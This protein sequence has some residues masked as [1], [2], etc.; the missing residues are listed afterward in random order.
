MLFQFYDLPAQHWQHIR[1]TNPIESTFA[2]VRHRT[3]RT[4]G[5]GNRL[6]TL[7]MTF[8]LTREAEKHWRRINGYELIVK[9]FDG[10]RFKNGIE[11]EKA[12]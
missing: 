3:K 2:T 7:T 4:K 5:C 8:K 1:T 11:E 6:A 10:V 9:V 12:A